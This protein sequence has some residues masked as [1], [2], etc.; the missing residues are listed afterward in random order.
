MFDLTPAEK[1]AFEED[2]YFLRKDLFSP[3]EVKE[4]SDAIDA[5]YK[6]SK[7]LKETQVLKGTQFVMERGVLSRAVWIGGAKPELLRYGTDP[8][9]TTPVATI[10]GSKEAD[11]LICQAHFKFPGDGVEYRWHQ[12]SENRGYGTP[13][14]TDVNGR[15]SYV[16]TLMAVDP[17]TADNGPV[18]F[19]P[20]TG[21]RGH[22][23]LDQMEDPS[24]A[25]DTSK[26]VPLILSP[27]T[28]AF[29]GPYVIH[30]SLPNPSDA[31]RR[32][33]I[34]GY[35]CPGANHKKYPGDGAGR[36][37]RLA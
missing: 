19:A 3:K 7:G 6:M 12:D 18:Q 10:L 17:M 37:I 30:G 5:I 29:F 33:F 31:P 16:Q 28:V 23:A 1:R 35:A 26:L 27:G 11:Q 24:K 36:R 21:K 32:I 8:R 34:N 14:W 9:I 20:G 22:L 13:D 25:F 15:G 2:G 4:V